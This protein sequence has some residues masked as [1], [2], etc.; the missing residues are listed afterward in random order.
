MTKSSIAP[1]SDDADGALSGTFDATGIPGRY[2]V[3]V[4]AGDSQTPACE[5]TANSA[6]FEVRDALTASAAKNGANRDALSVNMDGSHTGALT[7]DTVTY[8]W[9]KR[10]DGGSWTSLSGASTED[11]TYSTFETDET[12]PAS[13]DITLT[14]GVA[15]GDYLG[16]VWVVDL[17]LKTT[18]TVGT[19]VCDAFSSPV[20]V[21]LVKM[22]DP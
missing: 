13:V 18:R 9:Q 20:P 6:E 3:H 8:Q 16:R 11:V 14:E 10:V 1:V 17:R 5:T 2:R 19:L 15:S 12:T 4:E 7:G 22:V 21:K